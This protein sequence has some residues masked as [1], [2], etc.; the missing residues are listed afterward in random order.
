LGLP[1]NHL[2]YRA[3][4]VRPNADRVKKK[5]KQ[6]SL[7][8]LKLDICDPDYQPVLEEMM[9]ISRAASLWFRTY[10]MASPNVTVSSPEYVNELFEG[11]MV[12]P[13]DDATDGDDGGNSTTA[14]LGSRG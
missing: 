1:P 5:K 6:L 9:A 8:N 12:N 10:F 4:H 14:V 3:L 13:C 7:D 11:W 2:P